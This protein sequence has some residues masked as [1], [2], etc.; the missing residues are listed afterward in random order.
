[1]SLPMRSGDSPR[2]SAVLE[3][4]ALTLLILSYMWGWDDSFDKASTL[5]VALYFAIGV[6]G[7]VR[8]RETASELG[9]RPIHC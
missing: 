8:R 9:L 5:V 1:M 4:I 3:I 6:V 2:I 7:H